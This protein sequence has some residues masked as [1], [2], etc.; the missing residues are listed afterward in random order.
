MEMWITTLKITKIKRRSYYMK[1]F[2]KVLSVVAVL[3]LVVS[4]VPANAKAATDVI[5][6][7]DG[8]ST[9]FGYHYTSDGVTRDGDP[10]EMSVEEYDG[11]MQLKIATTTAAIPKVVIDVITLVGGDN[12]DKIKKVDM[13]LTF[14]NPDSSKVADWVGGGIG[15]NYGP[16]GALWYQNDAEQY[17]GGDWENPF[18]A[19]IKAQLTFLDG[20][21]FTNNA[22]GSK[23]LL[24]YWGNDKTNYMYI[25]NV[26]FYDADGNKL[27]IQTAEV[28]EVSEEVVEAVVEDTAAEA[29]KTGEVSYTL[30]YILGAVV[31]LTGTVVVKRRKSIEV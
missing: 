24:Q 22:S 6:F 5:D 14:V 4:A 10:F 19:P 8:S 21:A 11:S 15:A 17:S 26:T 12:I 18:T 16:D 29:P 3:A 13:D 23:F 7:E 2:K 27:A 20:F 28:E 25:D 9:G 30:Y 1:L 31:M